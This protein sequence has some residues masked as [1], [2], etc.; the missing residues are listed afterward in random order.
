MFWVVW[1]LVQ[2]VLLPS[3]LSLFFSF[4]H[5]SLNLL[6][7]VKRSADS[8]NIWFEVA[9]HIWITFVLYLLYFMQGRGKRNKI[10]I[11][12][13]SYVACFWR[14]SWS[15]ML[16][17]NALCWTK[18]LSTTWAYSCLML[19]NL[20]CFQILHRDTDCVAYFL[21]AGR[22]LLPTEN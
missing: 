19:F 14:H 18:V 8:C 3:Y 12:T 15:Q 22:L 21:F 11:W 6:Q 16:M 4:S 9:V 10:Y 2:L 1:W 7:Y 20:S 17:F 13:K 5:F